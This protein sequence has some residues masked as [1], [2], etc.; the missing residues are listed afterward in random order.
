MREDILAATEEAGEKR[1]LALRR[2]RCRPIRL[3]LGST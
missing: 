2:P 1:D 3:I